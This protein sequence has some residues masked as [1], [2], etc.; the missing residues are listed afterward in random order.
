MELIIQQTT[1]NESN[2]ISIHK[3]IEE[4]SVV[5]MPNEKKIVSFLVFPRRLGYQSMK[6]F[7]IIDRS[8]RG[9]K[10]H[11]AKGYSFSF[12]KFTIEE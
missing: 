4:D 1:L 9:D 12:P 5:L 6:G 8:L 2:P 11:E 7:R 10:E 3:I